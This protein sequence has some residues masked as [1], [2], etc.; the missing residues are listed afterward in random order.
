MY[1]YSNGPQKT[2]KKGWWMTERHNSWWS[3]NQGL[4]KIAVMTLVLLDNIL[5]LGNILLLRLVS[6]LRSILFSCKV[7]VLLYN[8]RNKAFDYK[9]KFPQPSKKRWGRGAGVEECLIC[10]IL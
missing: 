4:P 2:H 8:W 1:M 10:Y 5:L 3:R 6:T 7:P 9:L